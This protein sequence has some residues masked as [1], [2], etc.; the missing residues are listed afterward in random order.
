MRFEWDERKNRA[1]KRKHGVS[2]EEATEVFGDPLHL[3]WLDERFS[4]FEERWV[5]VGQIRTGLTL[6]VANLF[7]D[8]QGEGSEG[9]VRLISARRATYRERQEYEG[10]I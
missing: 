2:F 3:S 7:F 4:V 8:E 9:T 5:T 1:N 6:T 10:T